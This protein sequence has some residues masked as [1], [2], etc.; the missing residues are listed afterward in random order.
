MHMYIQKKKKKC[1][2]PSVDS[3]G[4]D[5]AFESC[6]KLEK[7]VLS[8]NFISELPAEIGKLTRLHTL[9]CTCNQINSLPAE[10][11]ALQALHVLVLRTNMLMSLPP[12][13]ACLRYDITYDI[14]TTTTKFKYRIAIIKSNKSTNQYINT[15][16][17]THT[18][19][20]MRTVLCKCS[21]CRRTKSNGYLPRSVPW[22][23]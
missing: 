16:T 21:T 1:Y 10:L 19:I 17:H 20:C 13:V 14:Y 18:Y 6:P 12:E 8:H 11:G 7:L 22:Y 2:F 5:G 15:H 4:G 23:P 9:E 3:S